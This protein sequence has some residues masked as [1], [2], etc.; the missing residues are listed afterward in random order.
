MKWRSWMRH[1]STTRPGGT[2]I[3]GFAGPLRIAGD[4]QPVWP[5]LCAGTITHAGSE[6]AL[7]L[8]RYDLLAGI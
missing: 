2:P 7:G 8:G 1:S 6:T 3:G 5:L 4:L